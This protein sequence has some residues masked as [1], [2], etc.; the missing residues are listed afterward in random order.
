MIQRTILIKKID[1]DV[2]SFNK[3]TT[4]DE[5]LKKLVDE[6]TPIAEEFIN[7]EENIKKIKDAITSE[8]YKLKSQYID[9]LKNDFVEKIIEYSGRKYID[10]LNEG[11]SQEI[12][13]A[14][15]HLDASYKNIGVFFM[16]WLEHV[17]DKE[18][19][20]KMVGQ[21][22]KNT[23]Y[24]SMA[25]ELTSYNTKFMEE[26]LANKAK[27][28]LYNLLEEA[29]YS[30]FKSDIYT[31][32]TIKKFKDDI[33]KHQTDNFIRLCELDPNMDFDEF[34]S[35]CELSSENK[36]DID[37]IQRYI[38]NWIVRLSNNENGLKDHILK[39]GRP[40]LQK[41][42]EVTNELN[43]MD[44]IKPEKI[45]AISQKMYEEP[46]SGYTRDIIQNYEKYEKEAEKINHDLT[47]YQ[48]FIEYVRTL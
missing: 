16:K 13:F 40:M 34:Y 41:I 8:K 1:R 15:A 17:N 28:E 43:I 26:K 22:K 24:K 45:G 27:G 20:D 29:S 21:Y 39:E 5:M 35:A 9:I 11:H 30:T 3:G 6:G 36:E 14:T 46:L 12:S 7:K 32:H 25:K 33:I 31:E 37:M 10:H 4:K 18:F 42:D 44:D 38:D 48:P 47:R 2:F 19:Y 23:D